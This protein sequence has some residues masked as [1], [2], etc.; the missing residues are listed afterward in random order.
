MKIRK[1]QAVWEGSL[2]EGGGTVRFGDGAFESRYSWEDRFGEGVGTNP[3]ELLAA[4][5]AACFSMALSSQLTNAGSPPQRIETTANL[6]FEKLEAGWTVV[7][8]VLDTQVRAAGLEKS[9]FQELSEKAKAT[10]PISRALGAVD[11][12]LNARLAAG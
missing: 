2:K 4:A 9:A 6:H 1:A 3:E 12:E 10:C 8:I 5:H 11:I 7:K